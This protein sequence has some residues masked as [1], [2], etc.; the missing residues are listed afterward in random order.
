MFLLS[1]AVSISIHTEPINDIFML[2]IGFLGLLSTPVWVNYLNY[3]G[4]S[5]KII[6]IIGIDR[7]DLI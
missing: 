4:Y 2:I 7:N 3:K 5:D 6:D 1:L